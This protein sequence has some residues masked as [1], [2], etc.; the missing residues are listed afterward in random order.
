MGSCHQ[1]P[2]VSTLVLLPR[3]LYN[4]E[5]FPG[6]APGRDVGLV[7]NPRD[8][9]IDVFSGQ[10]RRGQPREVKGPLWAATETHVPVVTPLG[11]YVPPLPALL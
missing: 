5:C 9:L 1:T 2:L 11:N 3:V 6:S 7:K 4:A 10:R 8:D